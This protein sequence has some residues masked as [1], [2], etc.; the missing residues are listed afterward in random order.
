MA[1][2]LS[3][4][5]GIFFLIVKKLVNYAEPTQNVG[6]IGIARVTEASGM[7][8]ITS[9]V[10]YCRIVK[11]R[12][13]RFRQ[14][15]CLSRAFEFG[16]NDLGLFVT[17]PTATLFVGPRRIFRSLITKVLSLLCGLKCKLGYV[18]P[19]HKSFMT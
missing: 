13:H 15:S 19:P 17:L 12:F 8:S 3:I 1:V 18:E 4:T 7:G 16:C 11:T 9:Q 14:N 2:N 10:I 5:S 6:V